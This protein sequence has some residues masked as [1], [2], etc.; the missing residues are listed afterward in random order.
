[1]KKIISG[2]IIIGILAFTMV[3][4]GASGQKEP[5]PYSKMTEFDTDT[6]GSSKDLIK[7]LGNPKTIITE[8]KDMEAII[9]GVIQNLELPRKTGDI[10]RDAVN[11]VGYSQFIEIA[12]D[13]LE[14]VSSLEGNENF[15]VLEY[16][17]ISS[18]NEEYSNYFIFDNEEYI[19]TFWDMSPYIY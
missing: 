15:K 12:E 6:I 11:E 4:C 16:R 17:T 9:E 3:G 8:T 13:R 19:T 5:V 18:K 2:L 1:M 10:S 14:T 7:E